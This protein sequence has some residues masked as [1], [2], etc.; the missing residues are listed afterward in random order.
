[1]EEL[2]L[3]H[4]IKKQ[5]PKAF[6]LLVDLYSTMVYSVV[7][8]MIGNGQDSEDVT[9]EVFVTIWTTLDSFKG[10]S[11]LKTWIYRIAINKTH[12]FIRKKNRQ[13]RKGFHVQIEEKSNVIHEKEGTP[14][15]LME[16]QELEIVFNQSLS[17]IP[18]NQQIAFLLNRFEGMSYHEIA[19]EMK[20]SH[21][22]VESL[23]FRAK[24]NLTKL[25]KKHLN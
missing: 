5:N 10:E 14:F 15:E 4:Q 9:Q 22:A 8:K 18:E 11:L 2:E 3:I 7:F 12:E 17:K 19:V 24:Q 1:V 13:K 6:S 25:M 20:T 21:S 23:I 16:Y